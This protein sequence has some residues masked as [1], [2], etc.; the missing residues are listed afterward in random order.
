MKTRIAAIILL[1]CVVTGCFSY[2]AR[3]P[4]ATLP[5]AGRQPV[6]VSINLPQSKISW[7]IELRTPDETASVSIPPRRVRI[8]VT[9]VSPRPVQLFFL[10]CPGALLAPQRSMLVYD[11]MWERF[12]LQERFFGCQTSVRPAALRLEFQFDPEVDLPNNLQILA[13]KSDAL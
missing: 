9:N 10:Q 4:L 7:W 6:V 3:K 13:V 1:G 5:T 8:M 2:T 11:K 12:P